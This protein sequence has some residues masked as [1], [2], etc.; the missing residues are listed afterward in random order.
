MSPAIRTSQTSTSCIPAVP[1]RGLFV[2]RLPGYGVADGRAD[3]GRRREFSG[4]TALRD[5]SDDLA[6]F[7]AT[8]KVIEARIMQWPLWKKSLVL[9]PAFLVMSS[10][11]VIVVYEVASGLVL[12]GRALFVH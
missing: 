3:V 6:R 8:V 4:T 5:G 11:L 2:R 1:R 12:L 10:L 9:I 7:A